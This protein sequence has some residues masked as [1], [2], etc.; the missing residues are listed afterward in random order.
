MGHAEKLILPTM[1]MMIVAF[2]M[3][4]LAVG[5]QGKVTSCLSGN[6]SSNIS[7]LTIPVSA[8]KDFAEGVPNDL[9]SCEP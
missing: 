7:K 9:R 3:L 5:F 2:I 8:L 6:I 1:I 4:V